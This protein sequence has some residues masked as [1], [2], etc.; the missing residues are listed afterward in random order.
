MAAFLVVMFALIIPALT[1]EAK[2]EKKGWIMGSIIDSESG[3]PIIGASI[4]IVGTTNGAAS[5]LDGNYMI[6]E[7]MPGTYMLMISSIGYTGTK[8]DSV[9]VIEKSP[10]IISI[11]LDPA[12][13]TG[14]KVTV[15]AKAVSSSEANL[16]R[17]RQKATTISDAISAEEISKSGSGDAAEAMTHV[18]GA[19]VVGGKY[20]LVRG[21]GGRY[22]NASLNGATMPSSDPDQQSVQMDLFPTGLLDNVTVEKTFTPDKP[23]DF[24]GGSVDLRTREL[25]EA[26]SLSFS[27]SLGYNSNT[28]GNEGFLSASHGKYDWL[29]FNDGYRSQPSELEN[30]TLLNYRPISGTLEDGLEFD[31]VH[32][33]FNSSMDYQ[34]RRPPMKQGYAFTFGN[35]YLIGERPL[36]LLASLTYNH[37]Y[38][39]YDDGVVARY[40]LTEV[41]APVLE[42]EFV[43]PDTKGKEEILW[44]GLAN[45]NYSMH[46]NHKLSAQFVYN[47][48]GEQEARLIHGKLD[49]STNGYYQERSII[50]NEQH[51][52]SFQL[53]GEHF[54]KPFK[55]N[56]QASYSS[57]SNNEP[58]ARFFQ[59][60]FGVEPR[61]NAETGDTLGYDTLYTVVST[62]G[63]YKP[64][65]FFREIEEFNRE[66]SMDIEMP[67]FRRYNRDTGLKFGTRYL[68]KERENR[69]RRFDIN[70]N[71]PTDYDG[72]PDNFVAPDNMGID[73]ENTRMRFDVAIDSAF[74]DYILDSIEI[75]P[76]FYFVDTLG[77]DT[78]VWDTT[79][80]D[81]TYYFAYNNWINE[82][83]LTKA[84]NNYDGTQNIFAL[85]GMLEFPV[86]D[87]LNFVGGV[88]YETTDMSIT[89]SSI[90]SDEGLINAHDWLPSLSFIYALTDKM[91]VRLAY[92]RTLARPTMREKSRAIT[93][94]FMNGLIFNGNPDLKRTLIDNYDIRWEMFPGPREI[95]AVSG[96][97]KRFKDPI[98]RALW[99]N[100]ND[101][102]YLNV[103]RA[104][105]YGMELEI[106]QGLGK[107]WSG[108]ENFSLDGNFTLT[109]S[110]INIPEVEMGKRLYYDSSASDTR[111]L[112]GQSPYLINASLSYTN[113][114]SKTASTL[115]FNVFGR[116]LSEVMRGGMPDVY[117]KPRPALDFTFTQGLFS[118]LNLKLTAR[119]ILNSK[120]SKVIEYKDVEYI[121]RENSTGR[122]VSFGLT[123]KI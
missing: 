41:D 49:G 118:S 27:S 22:S 46:Q 76:G 58:D 36:G 121:F 83:A 114:K 45:A 108:L 14:K 123:Y 104:I 73:W 42:K 106:R 60:G 50:Y 63:T 55:M 112:Q 86:M 9:M 122:S 115:S 96:F 39:F 34:L 53:S 91:N 88:R 56:W 30:E 2:V 95:L 66:I 68:N 31:K 77:R 69:E 18:T 43:M 110:R 79:D 13:I 75:F 82:S 12:Y 44:G 80:I 101:I 67:M 81:T 102:V 72:V 65:H 94:E 113:Y 38:S 84:N 61:I 105:V 109:H 32:K 28:T 93:Y 1:A 97:Y 4:L 33:S 17:Q 85:Y 26:L 20:V 3:D 120:N 48:K 25:P 117:E 10:T 29:A 107:F 40:D 5:D 37:D 11:S 90:G 103:S 111:P 7:V 98:E 57:T 35:N 70:Y 87:R 24:S 8:V 19:S 52:G 15:T 16:L 47:R 54:V 59:N 21:L 71:V 116:R 78:L 64:T 51:V 89:S 62:G 6:K 74:G 100:N 23:G 92:G 99:G 119:N